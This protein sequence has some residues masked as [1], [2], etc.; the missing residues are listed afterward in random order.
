MEFWLNVRKGFQG[1]ANVLVSGAWK[2]ARGVVMALSS[3]PACNR[4]QGLRDEDLS[5]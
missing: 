3:A 5:A 1:L 4:S 2:P